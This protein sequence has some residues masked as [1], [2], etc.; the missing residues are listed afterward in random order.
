MRTMTVKQQLRSDMRYIRSS[1]AVI[2][3][4]IRENEWD[5]VAANFNDI[6]AVAVGMMDLALEER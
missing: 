5:L 6:S 3:L 4:Q 1:L 2:E